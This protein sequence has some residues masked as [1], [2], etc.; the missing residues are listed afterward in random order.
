MCLNPSHTP[1]QPTPPSVHGVPNE[2]V[3]EEVVVRRTEDVFLPGAGEL[4]SIMKGYGDR[5][6]QDEARRRHGGL[7]NQFLLHAYMSVFVA[8][9]M[10]NP[11]SFVSNQLEYFNFIAVFGMMGIAHHLFLVCNG[12]FSS[13][14]IERFSL[15]ST[16]QVF[17]SFAVADL[18]LL[19][20][21]LLR[22]AFPM[23][24]KVIVPTTI[25]VV[26]FTF[27]FMSVAHFHVAGDGGAPRLGGTQRVDGPETT[28]VDPENEN[29]ALMTS[30]RTMQ[31]M[32]TFIEVE[33]V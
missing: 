30:G 12:F 33:D 7:F 5:E 13:R 25:L 3:I 17:I 9:T 2:G 6:Y 26:V 16:T 8:A 20:G 21:I 14:P 15:D 4:R 29:Q 11:C 22:H 18:I 1:T 32:S 23:T 31:N 28:S 27:V 10:E 24:S 19:F